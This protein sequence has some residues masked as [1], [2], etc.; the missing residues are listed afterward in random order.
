MVM[1]KIVHT[2]IPI[3]TASHG[4]TPAFVSIIKITYAHYG[5]QEGDGEATIT[6]EEQQE[7]VLDIFLSATRGDVK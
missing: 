6:R 2:T 7:C 5:A 4:L 1:P 3:T